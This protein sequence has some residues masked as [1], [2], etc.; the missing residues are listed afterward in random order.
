MEIEGDNT[1]VFYSETAL[2][3]DDCVASS[4]RLLAKLAKKAS[5]QP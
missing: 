5:H 2:S 3:N 1:C 4:P